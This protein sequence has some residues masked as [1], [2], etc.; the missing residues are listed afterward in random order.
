M[1]G[2]V[3]DGGA[4]MDF[5]LKPRHDNADS[6]EL[7]DRFLQYAADKG[8]ELYEAQ[9]E[10]ILEIY[11]GKNVI[12]NTP[13][14]SG[15]SLVAAAMHFRSASMGRRSVYTC[16]I[17]AL[18]NEKFLSLCRDFG[19]ENV[20][21]MTGDA[22]VNRDAPILC[23]TAEILANIALRDGADAKVDD[24]IMDEFH[25]YSDFDR[26]V[27]WQSPLLTMPQ[28]RFLLISATLGETHFFEK[29]ME[30][31]TE[32]ESLTVSS[33]VRPV[34]L[35]FTYEEL[36]LVEVLETLQAAN[37][38]PVYIVHFTQKSAADTAQNLLS[39]KLCSKEEKKVIAKEIQ[40]FHFSSPFGKEIK[41]L[42]TSGI[43]L[44]HAGL[45][46]K[47]RVLI[48]KLAQK[49]LLKVIC[50][51]DTLGV[52]VNVPIR[53]VLFTQLCKYGGQKTSVLSARDFHQISGRAGRK[54][55]DD[56]GFVV[57]LA[58]EHVVENKRLESKAAGDPKKKR[59]LVKRKP[60]EKGYVHWDEQT[61]ERLQN[62]KAEA[63]ESR[64]KVT[65]GM[66][67]N[68]LGRKG[69]GC[70]AMRNLI[71]DC[72][73]THSSKKGLRKQA[74]QL[75]RA[76]VERN[77]IE[78]MPKG[79][80]PKLRVNV[81]LQDD[82]SLNQTLSLYCLD[83][84]ALLDM[85]D[86]EYP[87]KVL[88]LAES[89]LENPDAILRRQL[90]KLKDEKMAEMKADGIEYDER[91]EKLEAMEY[92]K[93]ESAFIYET[94]NA[95]A[96][97]HPWIGK[98]NIKPKSIAREMFER[99][100]SFSDYVKVY[101]L[102]R[103]E[104]LLLR[105]ITNVYRVLE[106]TI[107]TVFKTEQLS[108][109]STYLEHLLKHVDS[110]LIDEW[111]MMRNPDYKPNG[112]DADSLPDNETARDITRNKE[113]FKR[114]IRAEVFNFIRM[115]ANK[116]YKTLDEEYD[117]DPIFSDREETVKWKDIALD[118]LMSE[119]YDSRGWI[120]LD[121]EARSVQHTHYEVSDD[122]KGWTV[123]QTVID[124]EDLNDWQVIFEIDIAA[125]R[126]NG[127]LEMVVKSIGGI[128]GAV[129]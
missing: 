68:V 127:K 116:D 63:L 42:L 80:E 27:A 37:K 82:F 50:G 40:E 118:E 106:N 108:E 69:D 8:I 91:I 1:G 86:P 26:G 113:E 36:G 59:K 56:K 48:E 31:V 9:E 13:T 81:E 21:M 105:H 94:F 76:L 95:F 32:V 71:D 119:Y 115:L 30:R 99:Y 78:I 41:R 14:G 67:L 70:R 25:Y 49:G 103:A 62:A 96:S 83:T 2:G 44:H 19:P 20:G 39:V 101:G 46:P 111:E 122:G 28:C 15:K 34:P 102:E 117:L 93:P 6:D 22:S 3:L 18:V 79:V 65:H 126:E 64:F 90:Y 29:E 72:H 58:P 66:L 10:A 54:G 38:M 12:L 129:D 11:S 121:P 73:N 51:T 97:A 89:I 43:G 61:F 57:A 85:N 112:E 4:F 125:S 33:F 87:L 84:L 55:F 100:S 128:E 109:V 98:E 45:L 110:S 17:K 60:P 47:Y 92:P 88:S 104:G 23:C 5:P 120:R 16:P 77:I 114:S 52:G 107:P 74:F 124:S 7:L 24:V 75:F 123:S 53:C 35:E